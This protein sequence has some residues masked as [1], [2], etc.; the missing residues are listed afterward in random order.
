M[1]GIDLMIDD[2]LNSWL[3]EVNSSPAMDYSTP[4]T[5]RMVKEISEDMI[6]VAV[7]NNHGRKKELE[8]IGKFVCL[9]R[10]RGAVEKPT[11]YLNFNLEINGAKLK[12]PGKV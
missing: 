4:I 9:H 3:I 10:G 8:D 6:K 12:H 11:Y 1:Y 7:D 5:E 2:Q